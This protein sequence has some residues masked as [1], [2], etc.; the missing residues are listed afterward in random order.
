[1]QP[2]GAW[3]WLAASLFV[4]CGALRLARFNV[5]APSVERSA[6]TGLPIPAAA[7]MIAATVLLFEYFGI[8]TDASRHVI[9]PI[10][11]YSLALLMVSNVRYSSFKNVDLR[12]RQPFSILVGAVILVMLIIAEPQVMLFGGMLIYGVSGPLK[13]LVTWLREDGTKTPTEVEAEDG[14]ARDGTGNE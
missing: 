14:R 3:G 13:A 9:L 6:F 2:F 12:S 7:D 10:L 11:V 5:Q 8:D 4:V 1:M